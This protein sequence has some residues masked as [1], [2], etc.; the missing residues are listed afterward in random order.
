[1]IAGC[2]GIW[3]APSARDK[4]DKEFTMEVYRNGWMKG[5]LWGVQLPDKEIYKRLWLADSVEMAKTLNRYYK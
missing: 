2:N 1:M 3:D 5:Y 4:Q